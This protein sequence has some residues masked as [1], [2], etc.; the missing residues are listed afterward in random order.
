LRNSGRSSR[1]GRN[2]TYT[3]WA[4]NFDPLRKR[5]TRAAVCGLS[6]TGKFDLITRLHPQSEPSSS[7]GSCGEIGHRSTCAV[8]SHISRHALASG[9]AAITPKARNRQARQERQ[10]CHKKHEKTQGVSSGQFVLFVAVPLSSLCFL[11]FNPS[12]SSSG[13]K[14]MVTNVHLSATLQ[15]RCNPAFALWKLETTPSQLIFAPSVS[16]SESP[17]RRESTRRRPGSTRR[18][19]RPRPDRP[20]AAPAAAPRGRCRR[21]R[22]R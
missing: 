2:A 5:P 17:V 8:T 6:T 14:R 19:G 16:D 9:C 12:E 11:L 13:Q 20:T 1:N 22:V 4:G 3:A 15:P 21:L 7:K 10:N 18:A